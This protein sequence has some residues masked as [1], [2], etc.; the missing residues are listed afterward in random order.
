MSRLFFSFVHYFSFRL[1][2]L[3]DLF[4]ILLF[5]TKFKRWNNVTTLKSHFSLCR[6]QTW[7]R[8][9]LRLDYWGFKEKH[10]KGKGKG[11]GKD[12]PLPG[13]CMSTS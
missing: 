8:P 7:S 1:M 6:V 12:L 3:A 13:A 11:K 2:T 4:W 10:K 5:F 9:K